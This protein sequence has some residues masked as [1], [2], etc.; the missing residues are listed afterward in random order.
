MFCYTFHTYDNR[1]HGACQVFFNSFP[2][3][4]SPVDFLREIVPARILLRLLDIAFSG[5]YN[6]GIIEEERCSPLY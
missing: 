2:R 5:L 6:K 1:E 4:R 3:K